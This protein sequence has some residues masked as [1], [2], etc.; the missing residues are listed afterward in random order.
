M[1]EAK[2]QGMPMVPGRA[3][4][5]D[6]EYL[7]HGVATVFMFTDVLR[8]WCQVSVRAQRTAVDWAEEVRSLL[9]GRIRKRSEW[10]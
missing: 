2:R 5:V 7:R 8:G 1:L 6:P 3:L 9:E 10:S 4:R